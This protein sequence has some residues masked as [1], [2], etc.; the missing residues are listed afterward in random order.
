MAG[1]THLH[2]RLDAADIQNIYALAENPDVRATEICSRYNIS[3]ASLSR[4]LCRQG[5]SEK[6]VRYW[7][8]PII[9]KERNILGEPVSDPS[10]DR[11]KQ[12][13]GLP[14]RDK[15][16]LGD[17]DTLSHA[18]ADLISACELV[19]EAKLAA[20]KAG[21]D[22]IVLNAITESHLR[23]EYYPKTRF[24]DCSFYAWRV[25]VYAP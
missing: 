6:Q 10:P 25:R 3:N 7:G 19:R 1:A 24:C 12:R 16:E 20:V 22:G 4:I 2:N 11:Q 15:R 14:F 13:T 21:I 5:W 23:T 9:S 17:V 18:I 8:V